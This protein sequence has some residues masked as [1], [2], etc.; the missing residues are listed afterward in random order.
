MNSSYVEGYLPV[1]A[2]QEVDAEAPQTP[3]ERFLHSL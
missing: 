2:F 3:F 1:I